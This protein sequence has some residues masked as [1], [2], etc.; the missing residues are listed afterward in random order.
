MA[1]KTIT[2]ACAQSNCEGCD[3]QIYTGTGWNWWCTHHCHPEPVI[4][5]PA[6]QSALD[7]WRKHR[8]HAPITEGDPNG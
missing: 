1:D 4:R 8:R 6:H 7:Y 3:G 2:G 5:D